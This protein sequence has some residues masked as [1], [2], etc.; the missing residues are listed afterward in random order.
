MRLWRILRKNNMPNNLQTLEE[1]AGEIKSKLD[2]NSEKKKIVLIYAFNGVGKTRLSSVISN[3]QEED[4][5]SLLSYNAFFEDLFTWDN[6]QY[7]LMCNKNNFIIRFIIDQGLENKITDNFQKL[8]KS[9]IFPLY[10]L[11]SG[12][13]TFNFSPGDE[14]QE[15]NIKISRG[16]ESLFVSSVF[17]TV[18]DAAISALNSKKEDRETEV[19]NDLKYIVIDDPVSS[20]DDTKIITTAIE[21]VRIL[22]TVEGNSLKFLITTH[23]ALFFNILHNEFNRDS[24]FRLFPFLLSKNATEYK[25]IEQ[26]DSPFSYHVTIKDEIR[27]ALDNK[28]LKKYHFNLFRGLL[29]K[30]ASFLGYTNW[31]D[32][33]EEGGN[34]QEIIRLVNLYSHGKL[35]ELESTHFPD[36]HKDVFNEVFSNFVKIFKWKEK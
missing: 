15:E 26:K 27:E 1:V 8:T 2:S 23:H 11:N 13:I 21:L 6:E 34:K 14:R 12:Q 35:S 33:V 31:T 28:I 4:S 30:T 9:K 5:I 22:N 18:L 3:Q 20:I 25:L 7:V 16:E 17:H 36:E 29:E 19:F 32:C 24:N 10:D